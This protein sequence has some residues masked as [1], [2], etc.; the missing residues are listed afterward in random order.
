MIARPDEG[1]SQISRLELSGTLSGGGTLSIGSLGWAGGAF[2]G[3][4]QTTVTGSSPSTIDLG[5]RVSGGRP[6]RLGGTVTWIAGS[7]TICDASTL[8]IAGSLA[9]S[10][11]SAVTGSGCATSG[12]IAVDQAGTLTVSTSSSLM[13]PFGNRGVVHVTNGATLDVPSSMT[14]TAGRTTIDTSAAVRVAGGGGTLNLAAGALT[15][16]GALEGNLTG[17]PFVQPGSSGTAGSLSVSGSLTLTGGTIEADLA[18]SGSDEHDRVTVSGP[19]DLRQTSL[20]VSYVN[21]YVPLVGTSFALL[22]TSSLTGPLAG[23]TVP[24]VDGKTGYPHYLP[25]QLDLVMSDC[26]SSMRPGAALYQADL[27]YLDLPGCD[28]S[29][30]MLGAANLTGA[31]L[32]DANLH[33][34]YMTGAVLDGAD[35]SGADLLGAVGDSTY[36]GATFNNTT[37]PDGTSSDANGSTCSGHN[38]AETFVVTS[39]TDRAD[40][41]PGDGI[42]YSSAAGGACTLRAAIQEANTTEAT[43]AIVLEPL[44]AYNDTF[45][46]SVAGAGEDTG[47]TGDLDIT[48]S[49]SISINRCLQSQCGMRLNAMGLDRALDVKGAVSVDVSGL[50][51]GGADQSSA[52]AN[53]GNL[54]LGRVDS[55]AA[56]SAGSPLENTGNA[57]IGG[58]TNNP[59]LGGVSSGGGPIHNTGWL[60]LTSGYVWSGLVNEGQLSLASVTFIGGG[61]A[62]DNTG[63]ATV[64]DSL[65]MGAT[66]A[67]VNSG[68][69]TARRTSIKSSGDAI[70][71][72]GPLEVEGPA[73]ILGNSGIAIRSSGTATISR[74]EIENN[75]EGIESS[76]SIS[77]QDTS[78]ANTNEAAAPTTG[79]II[80][81]A[82]TANLDQVT[83][84]GNRGGGLTVTGGSAHLVDSTVASNDLWGINAPAETVSVLSSIIAD[85][86]SAPDCLESVSSEDWNISSDSSCVLGESHDVSNTDPQLQPLA[87]NGEGRLTH[88]PR[89]ASPAVDSGK[90]SCSG[91]DARGLARPVDGNDDG[92]VECDRGAVEA[93]PV[94]SLNLTVNSTVDAH[95]AVLGDGACETSTAGECTLRAAFEEAGVSRPSRGQ[96]PL[97]RVSAWSRAAA[98]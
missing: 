38:I 98:S 27:S 29:G 62:L 33:N 75:H 92:I 76:A 48:R 70:V 71:S 83:V 89:P 58:D 19:A 69:L 6:I 57:L 67:I 63:T 22:T 36:V 85:Q 2:D 16:G 56:S 26:G 9:A 35:L 72:T 79:G 47:A 82:G 64:D 61:V 74:L 54:G 20:A 81:S 40:D 14:Q 18:G 12:S 84:A 32:R 42:C 15:G 5:V 95:D 4:G 13:V 51:I 50:A 43:D 53:E 8:T 39:I 25:T 21:P 11:G 7:V 1:S 93:G 52:I 94:R 45:Y 59:F 88:L 96:R 97:S 91:S 46:M 73:S 41:L 3:T 66:Q 10:A 86:N 87:D 44:A 80:V 24:T 23:A 28:L 60:R 30:A 49:L 31:S 68:S 77:I 78:V 90:S 17:A 37:C 34:A 55:L 65:F